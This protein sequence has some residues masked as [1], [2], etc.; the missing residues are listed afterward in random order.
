MFFSVIVPVYNVES[1]LEDCIK[2][3]LNQ[4]FSNY[5]IILVNDGSTDGSTR[6]CNEAA[7]KYGP[8]KIKVIHKRNG[9]PA[10]A[11]NAGI[12]AALGEFL[13]F[14]DSD[15]YFSD[16]DFFERAY[17]ILCTE[18]PDILLWGC[19]KRWMSNG[20]IIDQKQYEGLDKINGLTGEK[21]LMWMVRTNKLAI[22]AFLCSISRSFVEKHQ[23]YFDEMLKREEDIEWFFHVLSKTPRMYGINTLPYIYCV[24]KNSICTGEK[25]SGF[26]KNRFRAIQKSIKHVSACSDSKSYR[27]ILYSGIAYHYYVLIA[28]IPDEPIKK[29]RAEAFEKVK[30]LRALQKYTLGRKEKICW[31]IIRLLGIKIGAYVLNFR[32]RYRRKWIGSV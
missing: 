8:E 11:R 31:I 23:L 27:N 3:I 24:R 7:W 10:S 32:I 12:K 5:E 18:S 20:H 21:A 26:F 9:G 14:I 2:S 22:C 30:S 29:V 16:N 28:E 17:Q 4:T 6:I 13:L 25:K 19:V 1:Y 15:D